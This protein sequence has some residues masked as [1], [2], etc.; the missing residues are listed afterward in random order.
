MGDENNKRDYEKPRLR[1]IELAAEEVL[2]AGC[3]TVTGP[4]APANPVACHIST[5]CATQGS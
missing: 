2:A 4:P 1:I 3:K 5:L